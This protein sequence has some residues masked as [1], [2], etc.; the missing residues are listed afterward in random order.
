MT[1]KPAMPVKYTPG[2]PDEGQAYSLLTFAMERAVSLAAI[3]EA[4]DVLTAETTDTKLM[5]LAS[6]AVREA[7]GLAQD[8]DVID[9]VWTG[10]EPVADQPQAA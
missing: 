3:I 10:N 4:I 8:L 6:L 7:R 9:D 5:A 2:Q 1:T